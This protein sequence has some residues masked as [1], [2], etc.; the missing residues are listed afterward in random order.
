MSNQAASFWAPALP[1]LPSPLP[2]Q[3]SQAAFS[4]LDGRPVLTAICVAAGALLVVAIA[5]VFVVAWYAVTTIY[6]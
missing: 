1:P 4:H 2:K 6:A 3:A 5:G